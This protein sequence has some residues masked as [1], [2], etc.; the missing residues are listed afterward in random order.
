MNKSTFGITQ[1][2]VD[3]DDKRT[4][5]LSKDNPSGASKFLVSLDGKQWVSGIY[6]IDSMTGTIRLMNKVTDITKISFKLYCDSPSASILQAAIKNDNKLTIMIEK[7]DRK[8]LVSDRDR[9]K[10]NIVLTI[11]LSDIVVSEVLMNVD[12]KLL[13]DVI[14]IE[15]M[16]EKNDIKSKILGDNLAITIKNHNPLDPKSKKK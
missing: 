11:K 6:Y 4:A 14:K 10:E 2:L 5:E 8:I 13:K 3:P 15:G 16:A 12:L 9:N 7:Y 1:V